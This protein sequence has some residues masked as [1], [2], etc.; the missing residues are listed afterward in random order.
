MKVKLK[1]YKINFLIIYNYLYTNNIKDNNLPYG[2][3]D[4]KF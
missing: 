2:F 1:L 4:G 3:Y